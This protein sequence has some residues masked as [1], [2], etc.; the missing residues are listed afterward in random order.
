MRSLTRR[1]TLGL[2]GALG[3]AACSGGGSGGGGTVSTPSPTPTPSPSPSPTPSPSPSP[4]PT[5]TSTLKAA[6]ASKR[7]RFGST[8]AWAPPG[9]D[10][11][12]FNNPSY[13]ALLERDCQLLVPENEM[14]WEYQSSAPN[15]YDWTRADQMLAW[16]ESKGIEMRGHC[17]LW[18]IQERLPAWL[19][20]Y[21][22]GSNPRTTAESIVRAHVRLTTRH[23]GD[24]IKSWDVIN[25]A[26][27]PATGNV[28]T[29]I[30][31]NA[32]GGDNYLLDLAFRIAREEL[33][34]AE[35]VYNDYMDWGSTTHR[36]GVLAL[37]QGF[38]ARG[39][40]VDALG[41]QSHIGFYSSGT[42]QDI[43]NAQIP[44]MRA[45]LDQVVALGYKLIITEFDVNDRNRTGTVAQRDEDVAV[46]GRAWL[47]LLFSY[48]QLKDVLVWGMNDKYS[49]LQ[50]FGT[51][52][53]DGQPLR[54]LPYDA[55]AQP[56]RLY[57]AIGDAFAATTARP[58]PT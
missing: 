7:M 23:F 28:R 34:T 45:F 19:R 26:I 35:L 22:M 11:G 48:P 30:L 49:W 25:E 20:S 9:A 50:N 12:S 39:V 4:T 21:D 43:A 41:I 3:L 54:P 10:A 52:R 46:Y 38:R 5:P 33:P 16:A 8:F 55:S 18:Y 42:A 32:V 31:H 56:K 51:P 44:A 36:N 37:L 15:V 2:A 58:A 24:R 14:K 53:P 27:D 40:P 29:N 47:D 57:T 13:A 17:L 6:A 1:E